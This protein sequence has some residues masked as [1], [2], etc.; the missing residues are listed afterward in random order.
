M[1]GW[2]GNER[3]NE[4]DTDSNIS[5]YWSG[6]GN[7]SFLTVNLD[8]NNKNHDRYGFKVDRYEYIE[9][10]D[11][12]GRE[13]YII[14][15]MDGVTGFHCGD[16]SPY[17]GCMGGCNDTN[18]SFE[19]SGN[20][21]DCLGTQCDDAIDDAIC[22]ACRARNNHGIHV[23]PIGFGPVSVNCPNANRTMGE[24]AKCGNT[25]YYGSTNATE[26]RS[27][28][29]GIADG[30][31]NLTYQSQTMGIIGNMTPSMLYPESYIKFSY[32]PVN[33][34]GYGEITLTRNTP[35][36]NDI[37]NCT[38]YIYIADISKVTDMKVT[39]Y[40]SEYWTDYLVV[41]N[42][43]AYTLRDKHFGDDYMLIGDPH[44]IQIPPVL[45]NSGENNSILV[46]TGDGPDPPYTGCSPDNRAVYT[47]RLTGVVGYGNVFPE[48]SGCKWTIQFE[49]NT[50]I[51]ETIPDYYNGTCEC[52]YASGNISYDK[53]DAIDDAIFR[54]LQKLDS[55][56]NNKVDITFDS[57]MIESDFSGAGGVRS[58]WGPI[59][60]KLIIWI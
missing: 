48:K 35:R 47:I 54:L 10:G 44:I 19:C 37:E 23:Y 57:S 56:G 14:V 7:G 18:G 27:I 12:S 34:S 21:S 17:P 11:A 16:C 49:D 1:P 2:E 39:S 28:Y 20:V 50:N 26:L 38:G 13:G 3:P 52:S 46:E 15:M 43:T 55:N 30:I 58:L 32:S 6:W 40:S 42:Q 29:H 60:M 25:S 4:I 9:G 22:A 33:Y 51:T 36:F 24:I 5:G 53:N 31:V 41:N 8:L 45:I 59:T